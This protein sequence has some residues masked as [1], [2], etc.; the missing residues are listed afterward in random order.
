MI[1]SLQDLVVHLEAVSLFAAI[2][3]VH[4]RTVMTKLTQANLTITF[5]I[6][7]VVQ[8]QDACRLRLSL[9]AEVAGDN[10]RV[11]IIFIEE[12]EDEVFTEDAP[13]MNTGS[14]G[15]TARCPT[16]MGALYV[17]VCPRLYGYWNVKDFYV[18]GA[19]GPSYCSGSSIVAVGG[20]WQ[21]RIDSD[22]HCR[23]CG[24]WALMTVAKGDRHQ[25]YTFSS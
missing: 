9:L 25:L 4:W 2:E 13:S 15:S 10:D 5:Q 8:P 19:G 17:A 3:R 24:L 7:N 6:L 22:A 20:G 16:Y 12:L 11:K 1:T 18:S 14:S 23:I 21:E